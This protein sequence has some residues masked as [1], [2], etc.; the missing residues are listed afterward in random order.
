MLEVS[1][2]RYDLARAVPSIVGLVSCLRLNTC[3]FSEQEVA[4]QWA[5]RQWAAMAAPAPAPAE[6]AGAARAGAR[7]QGGARTFNLIKMNARR[8]EARVA[9]LQELQTAK[10]VAVRAVERADWAAKETRARWSEYEQA[11]EIAERERFSQLRR[12]VARVGAGGRIAG[13]AAKVEEARREAAVAAQA[14]A[15]RDADEAETTLTRYQ[16]MAVQQAND[17]EELLLNTPITI[18]DPAGNARCGE[19]MS[20]DKS[21]AMVANKDNTHRVLFE[22]E[23][24]E[25]R[26]R[27]HTPLRPWKTIRLRRYANK[28]AWSAGEPWRPHQ[29]DEDTNERLRG[30]FRLTAVRQGTGG[31]QSWFGLWG[32][33]IDRDSMHV[34]LNAV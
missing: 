22:G 14:Q 12:R 6:A 15:D 24:Q 33:D 18:S 4:H 30:F 31:F 23:P 32:R 25:L 8:R 19:Y 2:R 34:P 11:R 16:R 26:F 5:G 9:E 17:D 13:D 20:F 27:F 10:D 7:G 28:F 3:L 1:H 21:R 29:E